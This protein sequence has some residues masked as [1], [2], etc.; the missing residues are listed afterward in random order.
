MADT[1]SR[2]LDPV[3]QARPPVSVYVLDDHDLV[4]TR[5]VDLLEEAATL[6][7]VGS[8]ADPVH[9]TAEIVA[10][11]PHVAVVDGNLGGGVDGLNVCRELRLV[12]PDVACVVLTAGTGLT[13]S[14]VD[15]AAA[16]AMAYLL[17]QLTDFPLVDIVL[18]VAAGERLLD[19]EAPVDGHAGGAK[20]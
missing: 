4:R 17:K 20:R 15:A 11:Q 7:V 16:G 12:A 14:P 13:C 9:A 8:A 19:Q 6:T 10:L 2:P 1:V 5:V 3:E 18:R